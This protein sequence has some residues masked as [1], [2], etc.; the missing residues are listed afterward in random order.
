MTIDYVSADTT[1]LFQEAT[2]RK[3]SI[4]LLWGD[5]V[6]VRK[7]SGDRVEVR[8]RGRETF[9]WVD[10]KALGGQPLLELYF[11]DVEQGDGILVK[12]PNGR[13]L[14]ID[15]GHRRT[16]QLTGKSAADFV[17]WKFFKDY[18]EDTIVLDAMIASHCDAD[19]YGGL[20]DLLAPDPTHELDCTDVR[21]KALYHAGLGWWKGPKGATLGP[22]ASHDGA[23]FFTQLV[24]NR[25]EVAA[26]LEPGADPALHGE[27]SEFL[28][29]ALGTRWT[30][31]RPTTIKR[32]SS[33]DGHLPGFE[34]AAG[35]EPEIKVLAPVR[36]EVDGKPAVRRYSSDD[37]KNTNGNSL[38]L[39]LRFGAC[40]ILLTGDLNRLSQESLLADYSGSRDEF[41][42]DVGKACHHGSQDVSFAFLQAMNPAVTVFSS[43]DNEGYD[44]PRPS[45][46]AASAIAGFKEMDGDELVSPLIFSTELARSVKIERSNGERKVAGLVY[47]LVNVR[48]DGRRI[49]CATRDEETLGWRTDVTKSRF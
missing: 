34:S 26:A 47:G 36:F 23:D 41:L 21:V 39:S 3:R 13:H 30:N 28:G 9:G 29:A 11:I 44:H 14:M 15:G 18:A 12:T 45:I 22:H 4:S 40:R 48:T 24:G 19:H 1:P 6:E 2:G 17:D 31:N 8:A 32:L 7:Q 37:S 25:D 42:C 49:L 33:A 5:R 20:T 43:G 27:W 46:I 10:K 35:G 38:L 16:K